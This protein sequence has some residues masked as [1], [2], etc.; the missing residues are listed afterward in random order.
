MEHYE[1]PAS[2][3]IKNLMR[4]VRDAIG[5]CDDIEAM[6]LIGS[7]SR[8]EESYYLD[9]GGRKRLLSDFETLI[10]THDG[11]AKE[12]KTKLQK[13]GED[14]KGKTESPFFD[15]EYSTMKSAS[16][17]RLDKRFIHFE[18]AAT[19]KIIVGSEDVLKRIPEITPININRSELNSIVIHRYYHVVRDW[20]ASSERQRK[21][22]LARNTLDIPS[23]V[24]PYEGVLVPSYR[25]RNE[26]FSQ[27]LPSGF[28]RDLSS[29]LDI[30]L[31]MKLDYSSRLYD[32]YEV[33]E[34]LSRFNEG[35]EAV[36]KYLEKRTGG[37]VFIH[38]RRMVVSG[39]LR[40][41]LD[42][43]S[44]GLRKETIEKELLVDLKKIAGVSGL[45][46][47]EIEAIKVR[48]KNLYGY[49]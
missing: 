29:W 34:M 44:Q 43:V 6:I 20:V 39:L 19:G 5:D 23:V 11:L 17:A 30:C 13:I 35:Y 45:P 4:F 38:D 48:M 2:E 12:T 22:L 8:G 9:S 14:L 10:V 33:E 47:T 32:D 36:V 18:T 31:E 27:V 21:Y 49:C 24:L 41:N 46:E 15:F 26:R 28:S 42:R 3:E 16:V 1:L 40:L 25:L 7:C 37:R